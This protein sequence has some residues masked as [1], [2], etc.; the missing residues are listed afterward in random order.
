VGFRG[1]AGDLA[2]LEVEVEDCRIQEFCIVGERR[3]ATRAAAT[4]LLVEVI[5]GS[6]ACKSKDC[7][8]KARHRLRTRGSYLFGRNGNAYIAFVIKSTWRHKT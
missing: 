5:V 8:T 4:M 6:W 2:A 1:V 3:V 7:R